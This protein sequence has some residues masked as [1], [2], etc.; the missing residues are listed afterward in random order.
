MINDVK[1]FIIL[2]IDA[3]Y[4]KK[5]SLSILTVEILYDEQVFW[6]LEHDSRTIDK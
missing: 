5:Y 2:H 1:P 3:R 4:G 6:C